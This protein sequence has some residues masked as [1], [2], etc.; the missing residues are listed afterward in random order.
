MARPCNPAL[1]Q[2][3]IFVHLALNVISIF[4][5][6]VLKLRWV[7]SLLGQILKENIQTLTPKRTRGGNNELPFLRLQS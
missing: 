6:I 1:P 4:G 5:T 7:K 3:V 2:E